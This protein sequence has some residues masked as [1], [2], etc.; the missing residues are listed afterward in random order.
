MRIPQARQPIGRLVGQ[1]LHMLADHFDKQEFG[2]TGEHGFAAGLP[3]LGFD[4]GY[5]IRCESP[6]LLAI[7]RPSKRRGSDCMRGL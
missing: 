5:W 6:P 4:R 7:P 1:A 3:L 2:N